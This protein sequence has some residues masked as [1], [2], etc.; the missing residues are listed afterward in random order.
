VFQLKTYG[1]IGYRMKR[2]VLSLPAERPLSRAEQL[3]LAGADIERIDFATLARGLERLQ[4]EV[5]GERQ[6]G[7][8]LPVSFATLSSNRGRAQLAEFFR[9]AQASVQS[10]LICEVCDIEGVPPSALLAATS[11]MRPFCLFIIGRLGATPTGGLAGLKD[12]GL[13]G[14]SIECPPGLGSDKAFDAFVR[15]TMAAAK[16][17]VRAV[18]LYGVSGPLQAAIA[19][20]HGASHASFAPT[21][22][23]LASRPA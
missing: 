6:P 19:S 8:I 21:A 1:R 3:K 22:E 12:A 16:P 15:T 14:V 11:L 7:L 10:G 2:R 4:Q 20:H 17:V 23:K 18:M 13:H 5:N 9:A